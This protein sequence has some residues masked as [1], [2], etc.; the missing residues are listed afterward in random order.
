MQ[1]VC[2][3][4]NFN[5]GDHIVTAIIGAVLPGGIKIKKSKLRGVESAA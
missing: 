2:G 4:Q 1:I 5:E 3:A